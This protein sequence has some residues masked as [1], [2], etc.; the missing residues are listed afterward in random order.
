M[1]KLECL[2][3]L[4]Q[5]VAIFL[6]LFSLFTWDNLQKDTERFKFG[7]KGIFSGQLCDRSMKEGCFIG[8]GE[9]DRFPV[10]G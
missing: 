2:P 4:D 8:V 1:S 3:L 9:G 10:S 7:P 5:P 6:F